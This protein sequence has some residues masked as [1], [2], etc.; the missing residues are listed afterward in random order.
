MFVGLLVAP[1]D[2]F[3]VMFIPRLLKL[4]LFPIFSVYST[5]SFVFPVPKRPVKIDY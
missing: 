3:P 5:P 4:I 2:R 1:I